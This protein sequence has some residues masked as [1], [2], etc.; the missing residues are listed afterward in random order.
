MPTETTRPAFVTAPDCVCGHAH[1][2]HGLQPLA[3][4]PACRYCACT[5]QRDAEPRFR[6]LE[7]ASLTDTDEEDPSLS[8]VS[9][10]VEDWLDEDDPVPVDPWFDTREEAQGHADKLNGAVTS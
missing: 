8:V 7:S 2:A 6:V 1:R 3:G 9:F 5:G 10:V 4:G